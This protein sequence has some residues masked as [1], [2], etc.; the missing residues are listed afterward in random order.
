MWETILNFCVEHD[1]VNKFWML[2]S[3]FLGATITQLLSTNSD[4]IAPLKQIKAIFPQ[5]SKTWYVRANCILL[6]VVGTMI[7]LIVLEPTSIRASFCAGLTWCGTLQTLGIT[8][9]PDKDA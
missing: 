6:I 2:I 5:K 7:S 9:H 1:V 8:L 4:M 3:S